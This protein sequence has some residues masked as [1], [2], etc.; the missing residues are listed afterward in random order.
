MG[1]LGLAFI[2]LVLLQAVSF[3]AQS[4]LTPGQVRKLISD[5]ASLIDAVDVQIAYLSG[6]ASQLGSCPCGDEDPCAEAAAAAESALSSLRA[7]SES[8]KGKILK[9]ADDYS[10][11]DVPL[12]VAV[13]DVGDALRIIH[14]GI[15]SAESDSGDIPSS[16]PDESGT[17]VCPAAKEAVSDS[18]SS[19]ISKYR[20]VKDE[21]DVLAAEKE[22]Q[23]TPEQ[24]ADKQ[25]NDRLMSVYPKLGEAQRMR[26]TIKNMAQSGA[27]ESELSAARMSL[28][29]LEQQ[30]KD[31]YD[32]ILLDQRYKKDFW[33]NWDYATLKKNQGNAEAARLLYATALSSTNVD[34]QAKREFLDKVK[35]DSQQELGLKAPPGVG[36]KVV[37]SIGESMQEKYDKVKLMG[38]SVY[39]DFKSAFVFSLAKAGKVLNDMQEFE[40]AIT[41]KKLEKAISETGG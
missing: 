37:K 39:M 29:G 23:P 24:V 22:P 5:S 13:S 11:E 8:A 21:Y 33:T 36:D 12:S 16:C 31:V 7:K 20:Y 4:E 3:A 40:D 38:Y 34:P 30:A 35:R 2:A 32:S 1:K 25:K 17:D 28:A 27:P 10:N 6:M 41:G 26:E 18:L 14:T 15:G 9:A 19:V